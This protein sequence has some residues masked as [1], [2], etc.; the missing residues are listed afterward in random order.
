MTHAI[1]VGVLALMVQPPAYEFVPRVDRL[2]EF[3]RP[4]CTTLVGRLD[5]GGEFT[6]AYSL[7]GVG[8]E[9]GRRDVALY[10]SRFD[11][12]VT[13]GVNTLEPQP[14]YELRSGALIPGTMVAHGPFVPT[15]GGA[16]IRFA[17]YK[18]SPFARRIWN[19]P[20]YFWPVGVPRN[21]DPEKRTPKPP[22]V[23]APTEPTGYGKQ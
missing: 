23:Q 19:L 13:L 17:D 2:V 10:R 15:V 4:D 8:P 5:A 3:I 1:A 12:P 14:V 21:P 7:A 11:N 6:L 18:Y 16:I 20:G 9:W 22:W